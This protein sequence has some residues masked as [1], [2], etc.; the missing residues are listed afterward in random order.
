M[1][2]SAKCGTIQLGDHCAYYVENKIYNYNDANMH[3][4]MMPQ[5]DGFEQ[6]KYL[7]YLRPLFERPA[8]LGQLA[9]PSDS[10]LG[11]CHRATVAIG[12]LW[13]W[14]MSSGY[15]QD[16][17]D[18]ILINVPSWK[19]IPSGRDLRSSGHEFVEKFVN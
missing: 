11:E 3:S 19:H 8:E 9:D 14:L 16:H 18:T 17:L 6:P 13:R 7:K 5:K 1:G 4:Y 15:T 12:A 2:K 10:A